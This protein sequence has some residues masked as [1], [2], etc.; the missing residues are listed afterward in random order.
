MAAMMSSGNIMPPQDPNSFI[1]ASKKETAAQ[2]HQQDQIVQ[3]K[4]AVVH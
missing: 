1:Q 4:V 2:T 3:Q